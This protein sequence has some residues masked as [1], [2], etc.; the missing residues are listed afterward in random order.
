[1]LAKRLL[2]LA[3][4]VFVAAAP[5]VWS[6]TS[7]KTVY[8]YPAEGFAKAQVYAFEQG[9]HARFDDRFGNSVQ[10]AVAEE[11]DDDDID[12]EIIDR[13]D[14]SWL[15][16]GDPLLLVDFGDEA[17]REAVTAPDPKSSSQLAQFLR[18]GG[19]A[20]WLLVDRYKIDARMNESL[21]DE[22]GFML[23]R[24]HLND[25]KDTCDGAD[26]SHL[27]DGLVLGTPDTAKQFICNHLY[28]NDTTL[29]RAQIQTRKDE[30]KPNEKNPV[31]TTK[32]VS[33]ERVTSVLTTVGAG[34]LLVIALPH[35]A[36]G[37]GQCVFNDGAIEMYDNMAALT[38]LLEWLAQNAP[39]SRAPASHR[40]PAKS[41]ETPRI[42][43]KLS[44]PPPPPP[45]GP[46]R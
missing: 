5:N 36:L 42:G 24:G 26:V 46:P 31:D 43:Q 27:W 38:R 37:S 6:K 2:F 10:A 11:T 39:P 23:H 12:T 44:T 25:G 3:G 17:V 30:D 28:V 8:W 18:Q 16:A 29:V 1:M 41:A 35:Y 20:V 34:E 4:M 33:T 13:L 9:Y 19:R 22:F 40:T 7:A 32:P 15:N 14:L 21:A 45:P